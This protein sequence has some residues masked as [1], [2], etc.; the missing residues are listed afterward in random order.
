[1]DDSYQPPPPDYQ[2]HV[3]AP[4]RSQQVV[5]E[6]RPQWLELMPRLGLDGVVQELAAHCVQLPSEPGVLK[7]ALEPTKTNL[8]ND[9]RL[10]RIRSAVN[11]A[12]GHPLQLDIAAA[13]SEES[14]PAMVKQQ[15][16]D[17]RLRE[18]EQS[19][20]DDALV[21]A[22]QARMGASVQVDSVR[23]LD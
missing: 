6:E 12:L 5:A 19:I 16:R 2:Q 17:Q 15:A 10:K 23:P 8:L 3:Q 1:M 21:Q 14:S 4:P 22:M 9:D 18:A 11:K 7:L 20:A 13:R